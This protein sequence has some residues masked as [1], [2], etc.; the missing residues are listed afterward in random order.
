MQLKKWSEEYIKAK[1]KEIMMSALILSTWQKHRD[2]T[3]SFCAQLNAALE[4]ANNKVLEFINGCKLF[5]YSLIFSSII[6]RPV[7]ALQ[8]NYLII[9]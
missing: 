9:A 3:V 6:T 2:N 1:M 5:I 4:Y 8:T 7:I